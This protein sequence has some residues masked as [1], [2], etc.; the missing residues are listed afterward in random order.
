MN[1]VRSL[2]E[3]PIKMMVNLAKVAPS[4]S[5]RFV[6]GLLIRIK[7]ERLELEADKVEISGCMSVI[8]SSHKAIGEIVEIYYNSLST[9]DKCGC[10]VSAVN[11]SERNSLIRMILD[12][13][14]DEVSE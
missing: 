11:I 13:S 2:K 10:N 3:M 6:R 9:R 5:K 14:E 12:D 7:N 4:Q 1:E 8:G